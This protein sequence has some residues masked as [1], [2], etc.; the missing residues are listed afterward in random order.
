MERQVIITPPNKVYERNLSILTDI[1]GNE[2]S[3]YNLCRL[4][5][6]TVWLRLKVRPKSLK[7]TTKHWWSATPFTGMS[8]YITSKL[9]D[10]SPTGINHIALIIQLTPTD[11]TSVVAPCRGVP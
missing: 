6:M 7:S 2:L 5:R 10:N 8:I 3:D 1:V 9:I 11:L 4:H